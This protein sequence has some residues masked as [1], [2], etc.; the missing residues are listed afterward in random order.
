LESDRHT[1]YLEHKRHR[2]GDKGASSVSMTGARS[3]PQ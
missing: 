3:R 1:A 2:R